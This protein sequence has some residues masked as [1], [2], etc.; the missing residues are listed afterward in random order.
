MAFFVVFIGHFFSSDSF[1]NGMNAETESCD[2]LS[3]K[4]MCPPLPEKNIGLKKNK[5]NG[6]SEREARRVE[7]YTE[8]SLQNKL[9]AISVVDLPDDI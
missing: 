1:S 9:S 6:S 4:K 8:L 3:N 2:G 5:I 7:G